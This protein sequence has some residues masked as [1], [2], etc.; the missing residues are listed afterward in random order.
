[1][2]QDNSGVS[3]SPNWI[4]RWVLRVAL[5]LLILVCGEYGLRP[6]QAWWQT[7]GARNY[8]DNYSR[9]HG[10]TSG[11]A[12]IISTPSAST[13]DYSRFASLTCWRM[14]RS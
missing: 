7:G 10:S 11:F 13:V 5:L 8:A 3:R 14:A 12:Q 9:F 6:F 4:L 1:M 2:N